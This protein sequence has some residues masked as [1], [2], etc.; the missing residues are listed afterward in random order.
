MNSRIKR[1]GRKLRLRP[2][3]R[4]APGAAP[5]LPLAQPAPPPALTGDDVTPTPTAPAAAR[6]CLYGPDNLRTHDLEDPGAL[7]DLDLDAHVRWIHVS[8]APSVQLLHKLGERFGLHNLALEDALDTHQR[9]KAEPYD[10]MLFVVMHTISGEPG[11]DDDLTLTSAQ[12]SFFL[13]SNTLISF[14]EGDS[15]LFDPIRQRLEQ[16]RRN[17]RHRGADYLAY[18]ILDLLVDHHFPLL[19]EYGERLEDLEDD[20]LA[21][22]SQ[23]DIIP[24]LHAMRR[25]L[26]LLRKLLWPTREAIGALQRENVVAITHDTRVFIRDCHDHTLQLLDL[27][28]AYREFA[29][30]LT[31]IHL[32]LASVKTNEIMQ[33]LTIISTIFIPLSFIAGLYGM[34][35]NP[36]ASPWNMPELNAAWGY[37]ACLALMAAVAMSLL[38][39][40]YRKGWIGRPPE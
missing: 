36:Q 2:R 14:Y 20:I 30:S 28:E 9:A 29:S 38:V 19:E 25:D 32:S 22:A 13:T 6:V 1:R 24:E 5:G 11:P 40:F 18:A 7:F 21:G 17:I 27:I 15:A 8:G 26:L 39:Y 3:I 23:H 4:V 37:P 31:D 16:G 34:N 33:V 10:S 35:F 12:L